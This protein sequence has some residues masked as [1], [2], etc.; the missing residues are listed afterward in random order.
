MEKKKQVVSMSKTGVKVL[1]SAYVLFTVKPEYTKSILKTLHGMSQVKET[2]TLYGVYDIICKLET[3][4]LEE[5][6]KTITEIRYTQGINATIT[7]M[8]S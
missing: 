8:I 1:A 7:M 4:S 2:Y 3:Q 5:L 6:Q